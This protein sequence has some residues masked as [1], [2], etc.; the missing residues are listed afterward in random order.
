GL[1]F[2]RHVSRCRVLV[3]VVDLSGDPGG[4]LETV[5]NEVAAFDPALSERRSIAVGTKADLLQQGERSLPS[6][7]DLAVSGVTGEGVEELASRIAE[8]VA[9]A[10]AEEPVR[11]SY[12]VLRPGREPFVIRREGEHYVVVGPK[13][14]RWVAETDLEDPRQVAA[15]QRR[16]VRAGVERRLAEAGARRG[17]EVVIGGRAFE[18]IPEDNGRDGDQA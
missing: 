8:E 2:L 3:Y 9:A 18:F 13:V 14:E 16:L 12:L 5:R 17:D 1:T 4:D 15:L 11:S 6:G 7:I 10:R